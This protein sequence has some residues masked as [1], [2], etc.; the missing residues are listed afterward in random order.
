MSQD[1]VILATT[2][3]IDG[4]ML[5]RESLVY[6]VATI[7]GEKALRQIVDHDPCSIPLGKARAA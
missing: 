1:K 7:N 5:T 6:A 4:V 2:E 3:V